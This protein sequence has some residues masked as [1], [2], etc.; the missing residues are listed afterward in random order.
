MNQ[1]SEW[2]TVEQKSIETSF[3]DGVDNDEPFPRCPRDGAEVGVLTLP[4]RSREDSDLRF[5]CTQC[6]RSFQVPL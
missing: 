3:W 5:T 1:E 4:D 6:G 2:T